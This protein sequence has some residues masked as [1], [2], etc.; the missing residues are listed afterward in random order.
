MSDI[1]TEAIASSVAIEESGASTFTEAPVIKTSDPK[2]CIFCQNKYK[3]VK[4]RFQATHSSETEAL[5]QALK[6]FGEDNEVYEKVSKIASPFIFYHNSCRTI[7]LY[8]LQEKNKVMNSPKK[9]WKHYHQQAF[10]EMKTFISEEV[11]TKKRSFSIIYLSKNYGELLQAILEENNETVDCNFSTQRF[12]A[13]LL[14]TFD[15]IKIVKRDR[16]NYITLKDD[17]IDA[18][19]CEILEEAEILQRAASILRKTILNIK[20]NN[21]PANITTTHLLNGECQIPKH[22]TD[23]YSFLLGGYKRRRRT[24]TNYIR[25]VNSLAEDLIYNVSNGLI[26]TKKH[27]TLGMTLKSLTSSRKIVDIINKYGHCCSYH[28][29]EELETTA[30]TTSLN[31]S[32]ICPEEICKRNDMHTGVAFDSFDRY[33]DTANGKDTLHDT[34]GIIYQTIIENEG[35]TA[36]IS[37]QLEN[38]PGDIEILEEPSGEIA[39]RQSKKRKRAFDIITPELVPYTKKPKMNDQLLPLSDDLRREILPD[40]LKLINKQNF[41]WMLCHGLKIQNVPMWVGFHYYLNTDLHNNKEKICYLTPINES[42]T[43]VSVVIETMKQSKS[44]ATEIDQPC[45]NV[46]YDLA[47]AKIAMQVQSTEKPVTIYLFI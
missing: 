19:M 1:E 28:I 15:E 16:K 37:Q 42:P 47:I 18:K 29:V 9:T 23:F 12:E 22:L 46:T 8:T 17:V 33:I 39:N 26:K 31:R 7:A 25:K 35:S 3:R 14:Q 38:R 6:V 5:L 27:I 11:I 13:K 4:G 40:S 34:V 10:D 43:N 44:I 32:K 36:E 41:L 45:I 21:L 24:S 20:K 30:T 2:L